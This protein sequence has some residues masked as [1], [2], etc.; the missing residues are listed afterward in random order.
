MPLSV[1]RSQAWHTDERRRFKTQRVHVHI[2][3]PAVDH[4]H[5]LRAFGG[6]HE[7]MPLSHKQVAALDQFYAHLLGQKCVLEIGA[8]ETTR[9][10]QHHRGLLHP[11]G[12][13]QGL[14][15]QGRVVLDRTHLVTPKQVWKQTHHQE[16]IAQHVGH[17]R[18]HA[19]VVLQHVKITV[20]VANNVHASDVRIGL[21]GQIQTVHQ[22]QVLCIGQHL[23]GGDDAC[24]QNALLV[25]DVVQKQVDRL[26]PLHQAFFKVSPFFAVD[27]ARNQI[28]RNQTLGAALIAVE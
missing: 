25:V 10:V 8:V 2:V 4:I 1:H 6:L 19:K 26:D 24:F 27:D 3:D 9:C 13:T 12:R 15:K 23:L 22:G 5:L 18:G 14:Q 11:T 7:H 20:G 28:R 21:M 17:A 16:A